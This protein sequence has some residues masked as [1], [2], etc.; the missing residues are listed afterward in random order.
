MEYYWCANCGQKVNLDNHG[1]C[2]YCGSNAVTSVEGTVLA[3][4]EVR[5]AIE[6]TGIERMELEGKL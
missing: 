1:R 5:A 6:L 3:K 2:P 4:R